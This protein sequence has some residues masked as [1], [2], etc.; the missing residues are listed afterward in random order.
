MNR[1][2]F[3]AALLTGL[4][5]GLSPSRASAAFVVNL[6]LSLLV[7][8]SGSVDNNEFLIQRN[9]YANAFR[10]TAVKNAVAA[11][12]NGIAV[13]FIYWS[14]SGQQ[15]QAV[16]WTLI[17]T[18]ADADA[19][20]N[21]VQATGRPFSGNTGIAGAINFARPLF[22]NNDFEGTRLVMDISGD[23]EENVGT[24]ANLAQAR[25]NAL[26]QGI[27]INGLAIGGTGITNY[28]RNNVIGG[29]NSFAIGVDSF[30]D[31]EP[32]IV[33][34]LEAEITANP[35]PAPPG[36]VLAVVGAI[37]SLCLRRRLEK[38]AA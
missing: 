9:G 22:F 8:V 34:K 1:P 10:S 12:P 23:G 2:L 25:T 21:A 36:V 30:N 37:S 31:F 5:T 15:Q 35:V 4:G 7:D 24:A 17:K 3:V 14:G 29:T 13:N 20:A 16:A 11:S 18:A 6:E 19:F 38:K 28:Y 32:A 26:N 27:V 33:R